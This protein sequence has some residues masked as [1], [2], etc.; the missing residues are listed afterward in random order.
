MRTGK[1]WVRGAGAGAC[2]FGIERRKM[3][4][5]AKRQNRLQGC[6]RYR[7]LLEIFQ[8]RQAERGTEVFPQFR[9]VLF[10]N[11]HKHV[12]DRGVKLTPGA[13][14]NLCP[15][16]GH[17]QGSAVGTVADHGIERIRDGKDASTE[18]NLLVLQAAGVARAVKK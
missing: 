12:D 11:G 13:A 8:L 1:N 4:R 15:G 18:R 2:E 10:R 3:L 14:L 9:P 6:R 16:M 17:R 7:K 5:L